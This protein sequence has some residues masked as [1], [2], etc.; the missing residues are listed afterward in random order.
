VRAR[1]LDA[2][3]DERVHV[4]GRVRRERARGRLIAA[5]DD[6]ERA[7]ARRRRRRARGDEPL[8][9]VGVRPAQ[10]GVAR[11]RAVFQQGRRERSRGFGGGSEFVFVVFFVVVERRRAFAF[12]FVALPV[13]RSGFSLGFPKARSA[14]AAV[15]TAPVGG[16]ASRRARRF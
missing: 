13:V 9:G 4:P 8:R 2:R 14:T 5:V 12:S 7:R 3:A 1:A 6:G 15:E 10:R 11:A 16:R